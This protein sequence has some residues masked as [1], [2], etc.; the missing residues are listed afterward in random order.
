MIILKLAI[1]LSSIV[2]GQHGG[3]DASGAQGPEKSAPVIEIEDIVEEEPGA[4]QVRET[5]SEVMIPSSI[6]DHIYSDPQSKPHL[7]FVPLKIQLK[8]KNPGILSKE[9][10][11]IQLP[12]G[13]GEIDL[14]QFVKTKQGSFFV[15]FLFDQKVSAEKSFIYFVSRNRKRKVDGEILGSGCKSYFDVKQYLTKAEKTG[16]LL[17]NT[18]R[19]R[20]LSVLGGTFVF[21]H[22]IGKE[23]RLS[24]VTFRDSK[25]LKYFC[26]SRPGANSKN[27]S[28]KPESKAGEQS[29]EPTE[30]L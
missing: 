20:H 23:V 15:Q 13:G 6:W 11:V 22:V 21:A 7:T 9:E 29:S 5:P 1:L 8:E 17:L 30:S 3:H 2:F 28:E 24:Q 27:N 19:L 16:G 12:R 25:N 10:I 18:T 14:S 4:I 26:E